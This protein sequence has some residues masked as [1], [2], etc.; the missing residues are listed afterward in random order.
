MRRNIEGRRI[1][2]TLV[3]ICGPVYIPI[4]VRIE[5]MTALNLPEE[6]IRT[7]I[8][9]CL[10]I[11]NRRKIGDPVYDGDIEA[12]VSELEEVLT[13]TRIEISTDSPE[14]YKDAYGYMEIPKDG[15]PWLRR[16]KFR[17]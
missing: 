15:I 2:G 4:D 13:V 3:R 7:K 11:G 12:A 9:E 10:L 14:C 17:G 1:I 16:L 6:K 5:A 8:K